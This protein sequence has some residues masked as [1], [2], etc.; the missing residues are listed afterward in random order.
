MDEFDQ[1]EE[2]LLALR[3]TLRLYV[4]AANERDKA[5]SDQER[6]EADRKAKALSKV[7]EAVLATEPSD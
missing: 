2:R 1:E 5:A 4:A 3:E 7:A 6:D